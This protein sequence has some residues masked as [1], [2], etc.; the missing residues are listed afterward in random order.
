MDGPR[1]SPQQGC[2]AADAAQVRLHVSR[3][4]GLHA[5]NALPVPRERLQA[6]GF[7]GWKLCFRTSCSAARECACELGARERGSG[8]ACER[9]SA[10]SAYL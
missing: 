8:A 1:G 9:G 6:Q 4:H 3:R 7:G 5:S 10:S 2:R